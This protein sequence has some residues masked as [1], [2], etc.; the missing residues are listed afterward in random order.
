MNNF[1]NQ[2]PIVPIDHGNKDLKS[3]YRFKFSSG[4]VESEV[5]PVS[6]NN[7]L[8]YEGK[9]YSFG[10][11][12]F[13]VMDD[14]TQDDRFFILSLPAIGNSLMAKGIYKSDI[15]LAAG[16]PLVSYGRLKNKFKDYFI[17]S[18]IKF[19]YLN[20]EFN[21]NIIDAL[22]FPQGYSGIISKFND[23]RDL[24]CC[25]VIDIGGQ[26]IDFFTMEN[27]IIN[28][29]KVASENAGV[30][31]L[32]NK[33]KQDILK[34]GMLITEKQIEEVIL[35]KDNSTFSD[36]NIGNTIIKETG[37]FVTDMLERLRE[38]NYDLK[39]N[40]TVFLGGGSLLL[41]SYLEANKELGYFEI[42]DEFANVEGY[43]IL[44]EQKLASSR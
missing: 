8:K 23:Y 34:E 32:F 21:V 39:I 2:I 9:F 25:N 3:E 4:Y 16:L 7:L 17:R 30:I 38:Q 33:I 42:L 27:C 1:N 11:N 5:E 10:T 40:P 12:R 20:K 43:R 29:Q 13:P 28:L 36:V 31:Q 41:K 14:K 22:I 35:K 18:N 44:A 26:T 15:C 6:L 37:Q 24:P 19:Y